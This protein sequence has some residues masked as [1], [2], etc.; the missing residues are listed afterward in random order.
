V[1][2]DGCLTCVFFQWYY[3]FFADPKK[4]QVLSNYGFHGD[5]EEEEELVL[6]GQQIWGERGRGEK[7]CMDLV[8]PGGAGIVVYAC[9]LSGVRLPFAFHV[10]CFT[11]MYPFMYRKAGLL[12]SECQVAPIS[13]RVSVMVLSTDLP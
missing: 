13:T 1:S 6:L 12:M 5:L 7:A 9:H 8:G 2:R 10:V 4:L 3:S 11:F